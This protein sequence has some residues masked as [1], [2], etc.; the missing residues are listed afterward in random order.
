MVIARNRRGDQMAERQPP[1]GQHQPDRVADDAERA[2]ADAGVAGV[3]LTRH[4]RVA[5]R[6]QGIDRDFERGARPGQADD[7]DGHDHRGNQPPGRHPQAA[8]NDPQNVQ[9]QAHRRHGSPSVTNAP[10]IGLIR[11]S[12]LSRAR[13][14]SRFHSARDG[15]RD[16]RID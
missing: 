2:A 12:T 16:P 5:E 15:T 13:R 6:Q 3:D 14:P 8:E 1:A 9:E 7:G 11:Y 10:N 4:H